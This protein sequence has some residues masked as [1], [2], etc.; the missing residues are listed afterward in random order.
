MQADGELMITTILA[1]PYETPN[2]N[3]IG[4]LWKLA[5][6]GLVGLALV[7]ACAALWRKFTTGE[8]W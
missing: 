6:L 4:D 2:P 3:P 5:A 1:D 7:W 8:W